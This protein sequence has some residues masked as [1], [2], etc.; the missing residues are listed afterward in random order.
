MMIRLVTKF[1]GKVLF[2]KVAKSGARLDEVLEIAENEVND[3]YADYSCV[4]VNGE[5][6]A[7]YEA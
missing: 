6:Y 3:G 1:N 5:I 4:M 2:D 7:E